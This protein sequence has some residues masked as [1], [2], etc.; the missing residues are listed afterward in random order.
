MSE[1][2]T[3]SD[4][5]AGDEAWE[6]WFEI[7]S[8]DGCRAEHA[9]PL[10]AEVEHAMCARLAK[11][12]VSRDDM[13]GEDPVAFFDSYFKLKGSRESP[14]PLKSYFAYRIAAEGL[15]MRDFVCGTL[16]GA[17]SGR[18]RDIVVDWISAA[19]GWKSRTVSCEDGRRRM[20][21]ESAAEFDEG[22]MVEDADP[23]AFLDEE[24]LRRAAVG[25]ME[26]VAEKIG[27]EKRLVAL[28]LYATAQDI[29]ITEPAVLAA[30]GV[31]KSRAYQL[32]DKAMRE[33]EREIGRIE[34]ADD[35]LFV[36]VLIEACE[37]GLGDDV[38]AKLGGVG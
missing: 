16:F 18:V 15:R 14:K 19:K 36:R 31:G 21:W 7:C 4:R 6:E 11:F 33:A 25:V 32:R 38:R 9:A 24:P 37:A 17:A 1:T 27:V 22:D 30:L 8:V 35:P 29:A 34:G 12:G 10:R 3:W 28:L 23:A 20:E 26:S 5:Y 13:G 2:F